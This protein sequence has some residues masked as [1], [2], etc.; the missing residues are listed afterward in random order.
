MGGTWMGEDLILTLDSSVYFI[1]EIKL[2][3]N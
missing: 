1:L 2:K 3:N